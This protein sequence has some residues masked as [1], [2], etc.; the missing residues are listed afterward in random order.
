MKKLFLA[1]FLVL[2]AASFAWSA[3]KKPTIPVQNDVLVKKTNPAPAPEDVESTYPIGPGD[4]LNISVWKD[5]ALTKDV[6]VLPDG[7]IS[8]PLLGL[9]KASGKTIKELRAE[10]EQKSPNM[11]PSLCLT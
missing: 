6:V 10:I 2:V 1:L 3:E 11:S 7:T 8:F 9:L 5:E 4:V